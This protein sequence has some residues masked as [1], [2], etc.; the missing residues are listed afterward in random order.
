MNASLNKPI[1]STL[2]ALII[3]LPLAV[4][5][6]ALA[7]TESA[8]LIAKVRNATERYSD[9][10]VA[11]G[12]GWQRATPCVS[13]P[14]TGAMGVHLVLVSR[15]T[16]GILNAE[17]PEALIYEPQANGGMRLVGVEYIVLADVWAKNHPGEGPPALDGNLL[18]YVGAPNRYGLPAFFEIHVWAWE[19]NPMGNLADWNTHVNC[20]HQPAG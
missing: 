6:V 5:A 18:H 11:L 10:N 16:A 2:G 4:P 12:E 14:E 19:R 17:L 1:L 9:I 7:E 15:I 13:G 8:P 3:A 20:D